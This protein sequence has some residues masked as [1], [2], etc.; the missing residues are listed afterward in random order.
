M[1][2]ICKPTI[3]ELEDGISM[4]TSFIDSSSDNWN[5]EKLE[6]MKWRDRLRKQL[7]KL[8]ETKKVD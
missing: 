4:L 3:R 5:T 6:W 7:A 8:R 2:E 1:K